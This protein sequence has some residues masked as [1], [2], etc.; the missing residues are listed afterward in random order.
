MWAWLKPWHLKTSHAGIDIDPS[1]PVPHNRHFPI[2]ILGLCNAKG[3]RCCLV[4]DSAATD[5]SC[6]EWAP[7]GQPLILPTPIG[8]DGEGVDAVFGDSPFFYSMTPLKVE[9]FTSW[10]QPESFSY[11]YHCSKGTRND[12]LVAFD[13]QP[14][15]RWLAPATN[16]DRHSHCTSL[17]P[18]PKYLKSVPR[19]TE[20]AV[21]Y[22]WDI[23]KFCSQKSKGISSMHIFLV[24][25]F[26][27][28]LCVYAR[29]S[30][31]H[32]QEARLCQKCSRW[33]AISWRE[34][35]RHEKIQSVSWCVGGRRSKEE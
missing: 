3:C 15:G 18:F 14:L 21:A 27:F 31:Q 26:F 10:G 17:F 32:S 19:Q 35:K 29:A 28:I 11:P 25:V 30:I 8:G 1:R 33:K 34:I 20:P 4:L 16:W 23:V 9:P 12:Q 5:Q 7:A 13:G 24:L 6:S 22:Q 2:G